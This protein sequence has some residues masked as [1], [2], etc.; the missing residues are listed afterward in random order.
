MKKRIIPLIAILV[1]ALVAVAWFR[2]DGVDEHRVVRLSGHIE[3][4]EVNIA[5]QT[6]GTVLEILVD[7]GLPVK[8]GQVVAKLDRAILENQKE[9]EASGV[10][11]AQTQLA[12]LE[13][14]IQYQKTAL[15]RELEMRR[16]E[17]RQA[18]AQVRDLEE[19]S[20]TQE[21]EQARAGVAEIK[22]QL[23]QATRDW[24]RAQA[25]FKNDDISAQ[26]FEQ[27]RTRYTQ[28]KAALD[29]GQQRL[30]L[31]EEGPRKEAIA[32]AR[33]QLSRAQAAFRLSMAQE[34]DIK[35]RKQELGTRRAEIDRAK[36][37]VKILDSQLD[38]T[39]AIS[40]VDGVVLTKAVEAGEVVAGGTTVLTIGDIERPWLRGYITERQLGRV[41]LGDK[42]K[43]TTDSYP[44]KAYD[45]R[46]SFISSEAEFTPKQIQTTEER[47]K[48]V[49]R[50]KV[51]VANPHRELKSN[52]P[53]DGLIELLGK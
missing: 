43:L 33:A 1:I 37:Q 5:F 15:E 32:L 21:K 2:R 3:L 27:F 4:T 26:Q 20:R 49:Y 25:L 22:V 11:S 42:V 17:I 24:E 44:G 36:A 34:L 7:E 8:K 45:G 50:I 51:E 41:K 28:L 19:G 18:E 16:A 13:T 6:P 48:L 40:P 12:Q 46:I 10:T 47:V 14:A 39:V 23:E 53:V 38:D 29:Q 30:S 31:V 9:R 52:M 35:R